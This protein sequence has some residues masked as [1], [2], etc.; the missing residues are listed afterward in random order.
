MGVET[1]TSKPTTAAVQGKACECADPWCPACGGKCRQPESVVL[2][3]VDMD[4]RTGT[5]FCERCAEDACSS[6]VFGTGA[7]T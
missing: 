1:M 3:R 2:Y 5:A 4:D 6:G 7:S